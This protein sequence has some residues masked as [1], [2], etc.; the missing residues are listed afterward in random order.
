MSFFD[1]G[2]SAMRQS[3]FVFTMIARPCLGFFGDL[4]LGSIGQNL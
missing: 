2:I 3:S 4:L 1:A